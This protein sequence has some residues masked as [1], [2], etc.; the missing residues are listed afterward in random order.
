[1][2]VIVLCELYD[3]RDPSP[4]LPAPFMME[5]LWTA[6]AVTSI[7]SVCVFSCLLITCQTYFPS[8]TSLMSHTLTH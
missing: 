2:L 7:S 8:V 1:M 3:H 4:P 6:S 5:T